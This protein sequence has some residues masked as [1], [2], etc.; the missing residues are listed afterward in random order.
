MVQTEVYNTVIDEVI[1]RLK[2]I[3]SGGVN[4]VA[5]GPKLS[6]EILFESIEGC[7][8]CALHKEKLSRARLNPDT[9]GLRGEVAFILNAEHDPECEELELLAKMT[10]AMG[11]NTEDIYITSAIK[12]VT[13]ERSLNN[14]E[15]INACKGFLLRE[16]EYVSP[17]IVVT[18]GEDTTRALIDTPLPF[19]SIRGRF[20]NPAASKKNKN[21]AAFQVMPT[22]PL[23]QLIGNK[24]KKKESWSDLQ[25][26]MARLKLE[27]AK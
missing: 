3:E 19:D 26:I 5:L 15:A 22:H 9:G 12:C 23:E 4:Y 16:L 18:L 27:P 17:S 21:N 10:A 13:K 6:L 8:L 24:E 2:L 7:T 14:E 25:K 11:L 1:E 20:Q